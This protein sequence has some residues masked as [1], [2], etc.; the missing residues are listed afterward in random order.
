MSDKLLERKMKDCLRWASRRAAKRGWPEPDVEVPYLL[1]LWK[2]QGG[3]CAL[4]GEE[5]S[6]IP[7]IRLARRWTGS[8]RAN[9]TMRAASRLGECTMQQFQ[10]VCRQVAARLGS[11]NSQHFPR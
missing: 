6:C 11:G 9:P 2:R 7:M 10:E 4:T 3:R 5:L 1:R 8:N